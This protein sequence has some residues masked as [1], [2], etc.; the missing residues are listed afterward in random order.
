[1]AG[2]RKAAE[3][4]ILSNIE[5]MLP[6]SKNTSIMK[7]LFAEM[8][9]K[10]FATYIDDL[11]SG[12]KFI[13]VFV[14]NFA[15]SDISVDRNLALAD[16]LGHKFF[17]KLWIEGKDDMP[18]YLTPIE[19]LVVDLPLRR[20]S[21]SLTKKVSVP[22]SNRVI[23]AL[24]GQATGESRGARI[25]Y[26]ELQMCAA[27]NMEDTMVELMKYRGGDSRGYAA[28]NAMISKTGIARQDT[29]QNYASGVESTRTLKT[30]LTG[31]HLRST[32]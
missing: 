10:E 5:T 22:K 14:P 28:M 15:E 13:K 12:K 2:N 19:Y 18:S 23:D 11:E 7:E 3:D 4:F 8:S 9:D 31:A 6:G 1:M 17:Q 27:M 29:L 25:S 30:F 20:A 26:P 24:T 16:K 32:L 21:Q